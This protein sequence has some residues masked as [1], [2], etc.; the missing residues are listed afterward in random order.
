MDNFEKYI[1]EHG[2][3]MN[4]HKL[5]KG[6][7]WERIDGELTTAEKQVR[8]MP[9]IRWIIGAAA[10]IFLALFVG[11]RTTSS[12]GSESNSY[13]ELMEV[14]NYYTVMISN[15]IAELEAS[16]ILTPEQETD[17]LSYLE[18]LDT[19]Y[20]VL[21]SELNKNINNREVMEAIVQNLRKRI[22]LI[23]RFIDLST[24]ENTKI[25]EDQIS[26]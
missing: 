4:E 22:D 26:L 18:G 11:I 14:N 13:S 12:F 5:D 8:K 1:S 10:F 21:K 2:A 23:E 15:K 25:D 17:F 24:K 6:A 3:E 19:E 16:Q 7:L 9:S 20:D